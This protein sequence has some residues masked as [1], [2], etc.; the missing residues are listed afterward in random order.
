MSVDISLEVYGGV[1]SGM[2]A[3]AIAMTH[4]RKVHCR[5]LRAV[6]QPLTHACDYDLHVSNLPFVE[7]ILRPRQVLAM[8]WRLPPNV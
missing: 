4:S 2:Q 1:S 6:W 8:Y 3:A 7:G 5:G